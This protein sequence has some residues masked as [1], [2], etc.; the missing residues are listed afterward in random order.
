MVDGD[1]SLPHPFSKCHGNPLIVLEK[2]SILVLFLVTKLFSIYYQRW[3]RFPRGIINHM[4]KKNLMSPRKKISSSSKGKE[5]SN[6]YAKSRN[7]CSS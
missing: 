6:P 7:S 3:W 1:G 5:N 2:P 4:P